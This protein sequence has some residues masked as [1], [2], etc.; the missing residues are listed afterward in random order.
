MTVKNAFVV[1]IVS[2]LISPVERVFVLMLFIVAFNP[3]IF[4]VEIAIVF[5]LIIDAKFTTSNV[6]AVNVLNV[7]TI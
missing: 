5:T 1:L 7:L 3:V 6:L 2:D 4:P